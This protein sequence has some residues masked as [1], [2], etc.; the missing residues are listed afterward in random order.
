MPPFSITGVDFTG[1]LYVKQNSEEIKVYLCLFTCATTRAVH[2]E[3]VTYLSTGT[4]LLAFRRFD[5][6]RSL[7]VVM[8][9]HNAS[10]Y[11][12]PAEELTRLFTSEELSTVLGRESTKWNF[13]SK[14]V[15][16]FGGYW[17]RLIR[18]TKMTIKKT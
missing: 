4:F 18:L 6:R 7:P 3:V 17:E 9:L 14:K 15:P 1:A 16:W 13:I 10:T 11:I 2:L 5:S 12:S 8:M